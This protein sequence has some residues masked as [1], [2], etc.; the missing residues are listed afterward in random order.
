MK[1]KFNGRMSDEYN[2]VLT[3]LQETSFGMTR[4]IIKGEKTKYRAKSNHWGTKYSE[5]L[6]FTM[7]IMKN[8]CESSYKNLKFQSS[9]IRAINAWLTSPQYPQSLKIFSNYY[10]EEIEYFAIF[11]DIT[12]E[13]EGDIYELSFVV[14]CNAPYGWSKEYKRELTST[15]SAVTALN[16]HNTSDEY[17][18]YVY[19]KIEIMPTAHGT[20]TITSVTDK[21]TLSFSALK[22]NKII[23]DSEKRK[24]LDSTG[25]LLTFEDIGIQDVDQI[26]FPKL[27][28][29]KNELQITGDAEIVLTYKE[30]RKVGAFV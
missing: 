22:N 8:P 28:S 23:I 17:E 19:P 5:D 25:V 3:K 1:F 2:I 13:D 14:E 6:S 27:H 26:Y 7:T 24:F 10:E 21:K 30:P 9:E 29:G 20:I 4:E 12:T 16:I 18:S 11:T 15:S